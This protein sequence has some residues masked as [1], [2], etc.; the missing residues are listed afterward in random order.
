MKGVVLAGGTGSRLFPLTKVT[1]KHLL[2]VGRYPMIF[3]P[4]A[5]LAEAGI[6]DILVITGTEHMGDLVRVLGSGH[7]LGLEFT[8]RVQDDPGGIAQALSLAKAFVGNDLCTVLLGDNIFAYPI[9]SY[10][11]AFQEQG[12][13]AMLLLREVPDP[14][15]YGI[16][17]VDPHT[18]LILAIE[19]KPLRP[20]SS[21][22]VTG[23]YFYDPTVFK[24]IQTLRPSARGELEITDVNNVYIRQQSLNHEI[25]PGWWT[26]AGTFASWAKA[27]RW[28]TDVSIGLFDRNDH[29]HVLKA[30]PRTS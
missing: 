10:V 28:A 2:P 3:H 18:G 27:N 12:Q 8:Y 6:T 16:A 17:E 21:L 20:R 24:I 5:K 15:R 14:E 23:V 11:A 1:N 4:I 9:G 26:D 25:L 19:E 22:A 7:A 30:T 13:G 29:Y